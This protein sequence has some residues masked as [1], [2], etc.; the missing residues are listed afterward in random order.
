[1]IMKQLLSILKWSGIVLATLL[2]LLVVTIAMR[3]DLKFDA[4]Y[5]DVKATKDSAVIARG[6]HIVFSQAHC[7]T[8][9]SQQ[10][11]DSLIA[12]GQ[13]PSL[14]GGRLFDLGIAKIY[15]ANLTSDTSFGIG[16]RTDGE[17]A[18]VLRYGVHAN[19]NAV[20]EFMGFH[21][22]SDAD[23][24]A[25]ISY[26]RTQKPVPYAVPKAEFSLL[27]KVIKA[28]LI[29]P[30]GPARPLTKDVKPDS[31]AAYGEYI[32]HSTTNCVGCHTQRDLAGSYSGPLMAGGNKVGELITPNL[33]TDSSSRI[34]GW[35][36]QMFIDRFRKGRI[37]PQSEMPWSSF[38]YMTDLELK[39]VYRYLK[40]LPPAKMPE[41]K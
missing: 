23:L 26:L 18:R 30:N 3:Q 15:T 16:K 21:D 28:F 27:G 33:T 31:T 2:V 38:T 37:I 14:S 36:E 19:G 29:R 11:V 35:T 6:K 32:V 1:M 12:L 5:P 7:P 40:T 13:E 34:F 22:L 20:P 8:C 25:V 9:H 10:N 41:V 39:A 17:I 24:T 4:P